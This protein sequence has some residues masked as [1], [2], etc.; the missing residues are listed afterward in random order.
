MGSLRE[1]VV[2]MRL[3]VCDGRETD[4]DREERKT[5]RERREI[6]LSHEKLKRPYESEMLAFGE[7]KKLNHTN[8]IIFLCFHLVSH[9]ENI[10]EVMG[11]SCFGALKQTKVIITSF[12]ELTKKN[13][14]ENYCSV[15]H[16]F[17][18]NSLQYLLFLIS[19]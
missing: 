11:N 12:L 14:T 17:N 1:R 15:I 18:E 2:C 4:R 13:N 10:M 7:R 5:E 16:I 6:N 19:T 9:W 8:S 3:Y